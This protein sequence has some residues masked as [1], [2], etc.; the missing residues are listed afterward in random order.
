MKIAVLITR[1][2][3][4]LIYLVFGLNFFFHFIPM[5]TPPMSAAATAFQGGLFGSGY[6][7]QFLKVTEVI[8]GLFLLI[9]RFTAFFLIVLF[10][11]SLN[12]FLFHTILAP[13]GMPMGVGILAVHLFLG[14]AYFNYYKPMFT[15]KPVV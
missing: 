1:S 6:F 13:A 15:A 8:S 9:N 2:L 10:P 12:I 5:K 4:G 11:I 3:L 7:F 14:Y